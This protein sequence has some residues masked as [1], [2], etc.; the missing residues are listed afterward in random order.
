[1]ASSKGG[2]GNSGG[3]WE[4]ANS[5]QTT[6]ERLRVDID[7]VGARRQHAVSVAPECLYEHASEV[8]AIAQWHP[9]TGAQR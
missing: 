2:D 8:L 5:W 9:V 7:G 1:L 4:S 3:G 6:D